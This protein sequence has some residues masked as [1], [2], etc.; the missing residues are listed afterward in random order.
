[1]R[2]AKELVGTATVVGVIIGAAVAAAGHLRKPASTL[3]SRGASAARDAADRA[4]EKAGETLQGLRGAGN[5]L[6]E[7]AEA[8]F[9]DADRRPYEERTVKE[10]YGLAAE[11]EIAGRSGM[12]KA[13][14]IEAL[15]AQ[16]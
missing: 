5:E 12:S 6:K 7:R 8:A 16:H 4:R 13:E 1:M 10:L 15:R 11:R 14:L 3:L 2:I 9:E